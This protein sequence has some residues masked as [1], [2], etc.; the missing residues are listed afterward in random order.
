MVAQGYVNVQK[1]PHAELYIYNYAPI[2]QY[3]KI[4]NEATRACRGL[5]LD[6]DMNIVARPFS[7]FFNYE[8]HQPHE[9][10]NEPFEI[11]EKLDGSLGILYWIGDRPY[12]ATRGSFNSDQAI[13]ASLILERYKDSFKHLRKDV[14]YLFEIIYPA[15]RIVVD[16][17]DI[18][19]I[20]LIAVIDNATGKDISLDG[21]EV[22]FETNK[23]VKGW[24]LTP[25]DLLKLKT[26]L[27]KHRDEGFVVLFKS[28]FRVKVKHDE[29][30]RLH[31]ILTGVTSITVW[32]YLRDGKD[33][34]E[35]L[36]RVP[37]EFFNWLNATR[38]DLSNKYNEILSQIHNKYYS[39]CDR[40][41][42]AEKIKNEP[43]EIQHLLFS[44]LNSY[45]KRHSDA[46]WEYVKPERIKP[47][48]IEI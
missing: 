21:L 42:Y 35:L 44:R 41:I 47:F 7:K 12:I 39:L 33:F 3:E 46:M 36:D 16:Y 30:V 22:P 6:K 1:H 15:N 18:S 9:I 31:R 5:I 34:D 11:F 28:G 40:K 2:C 29:Y 45:S 19:D 37:D 4:W 14:T 17:G 13:T 20:F 26:S 23:R 43:E 27:Y 8:E 32:E 25:S 48:R 24:D 38:T 10:P